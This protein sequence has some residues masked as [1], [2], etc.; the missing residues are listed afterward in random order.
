MDEST[1]PTLSSANVQ[2]ATIKNSNVTRWSSTLTM[3]RSFV[4]NVT[5]INIC[6]GYAEN[7]DLIIQADEAKML[8]GLQRFL[9][10]FEE[11]TVILQGQSYPTL[12]LNILFYDNIKEMLAE[13]E[14]EAEHGL[15]IDLYNY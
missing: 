5:T 14:T 11:R 7:A 13:Q 3:I 2:F 8:G 15:I 1:L 9:Q 10:I 6:I 4:K 12:S